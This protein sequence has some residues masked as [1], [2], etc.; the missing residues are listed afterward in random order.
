M[1]GGR[2]V[3][4]RPHDG[5]AVRELRL[6]RGGRYGRGHGEHGLLRR[7]RRADLGQQRL[8]VL[9]LHGDDDEPG[10]R[11]GLGVRERRL[12]AVPLVQ[13]VGAL[14]AARGDDDL[15]LL[16]PARRQQAGDE[17]LAD[18]PAAEDRDPP[19][20]DPSLGGARGRAPARG[21]GPSR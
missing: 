20:H 11:D 8:E 15:A 14:L 18:L 4:H 2:R 1:D 12:D 9:R 16:P 7:Q 6:D 10:A 17:R 13:L 3:R 21:R 19:S 5:H